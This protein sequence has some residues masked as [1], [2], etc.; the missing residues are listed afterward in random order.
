MFYRIHTDVKTL[1]VSESSLIER[2]D[3]CIYSLDDPSI[4][5]ACQ[6][7]CNLFYCDQV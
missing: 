6:I 3:L 7:L 5:V 1:V 4:L 2:P